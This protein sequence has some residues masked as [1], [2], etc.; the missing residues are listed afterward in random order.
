MIGE[1]K[2]MIKCPNCG[3]TA[4]VRIIDIMICDTYVEITYQCG[5]TPY[6]TVTRMKKEEYEEWIK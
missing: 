1:R 2:K 4:Q 6:Q 5:C 3:S